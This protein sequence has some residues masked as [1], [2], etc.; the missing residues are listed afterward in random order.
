[1]LKKKSVNKKF[2]YIQCG[3]WEGFTAAKNPNEACVSALSQS[4]DLFGDKNKLTK[5]MV[6]MDCDSMLNESDLNS[7][8][9]K[10]Y[11]ISAHLVEP[12]LEKIHEY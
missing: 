12:L 9:E 2:Y 6:C 10:N 3:D 7:D 1:M 8:A 5:I 4:V 11:S